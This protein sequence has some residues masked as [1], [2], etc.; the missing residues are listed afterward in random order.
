VQIKVATSDEKVAET[1]YKFLATNSNGW[2][3]CEITAA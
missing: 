2:W 3:V 1:K